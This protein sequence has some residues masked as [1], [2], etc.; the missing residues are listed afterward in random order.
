MR[1]YDHH[2]PDCNA[3]QW[4]EEMQRKADEA[5]RFVTEEMLLK[6]IE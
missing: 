3:D 4:A 2:D 6:S 5:R 1:Q